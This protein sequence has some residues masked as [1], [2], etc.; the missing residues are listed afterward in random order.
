LRHKEEA[1]D[2]GQGGQDGRLTSSHELT[3]GK[4]RAL[5][6]FHSAQIAYEGDGTMFIQIAVAFNDKPSETAAF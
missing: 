1:G 5:L 4:G 6:S 2:D 3:V